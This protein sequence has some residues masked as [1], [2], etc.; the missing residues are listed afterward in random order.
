MDIQRYNDLRLW[1]VVDTVDFI[2][3]YVHP[4]PKKARD[5]FR[6]CLKDSNLIGVF[7]AQG[8]TFEVVRF[9]VA[10]CYRKTGGGL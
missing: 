4:D 10:G 8:H 7:P 9:D 1:A 5:F 2:V 3:V 6:R